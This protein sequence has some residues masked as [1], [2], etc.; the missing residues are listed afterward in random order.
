M[1]KINKIGGKMKRL[2]LLEMMLF[3]AMGAWATTLPDLPTIASVA[4]DDSLYIW[5]KSGSIDCSISVLDME[6]HILGDAEIGG[7]A[8]RDIVTIDDT[9]TLTN[10]RLTS[11]KINSATAIT[12]VGLDVNILSGS[13]AA[14]ITNTEFEYLNGVTSAIQTQ[15]DAKADESVTE[16]AAYMYLETW[17]T[18]GAETTKNITEATIRTY[19]GWSTSRRIQVGITIEFWVDAGSSKWTFVAKTNIT[20]EEATVGADTYL[21]EI[22]ITGLA[23]ST[24]Y[25]IAIICKYVDI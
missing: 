15:L 18:G 12:S 19:L 16:E 5:D 1:L 24:K 7:T 20:L 22:K 25:K 10:K 6:E 17:T 23:V 13:A 8:A 9:Q 2:L 14:G 4:D 11:P 21:K 3:I